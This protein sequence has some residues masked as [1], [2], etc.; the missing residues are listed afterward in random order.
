MTKL[1]TINNVVKT[2]RSFVDADIK[3]GDARAKLAE[4]LTAHGF[5]E[6][7]LRGTWTTYRR[8]ELTNVERSMFWDAMFVSLSSV[9]I[10]GKRL[11]EVEV[12]EIMSSFEAAA[13]DNRKTYQG[14][15]MGTIKDTVTWMG[16]ATSFYTKSIKKL[17][18]EPKDKKERTKSPAEVLVAK[19]LAEIEKILQSTNDIDGVDIPTM[20]QL[21]QEMKTKFK[22]K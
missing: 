7:N 11:N 6:D 15:P 16:Q 21:V 20:V 5:T 2:A 12:R 13:R 3:L 8:G 9:K 4:Q 14:T 19:K 10:K 22:T 1:E 17:V 18:A